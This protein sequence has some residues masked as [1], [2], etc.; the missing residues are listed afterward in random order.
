MKA[1]LGELQRTFAT[2][3]IVG[4]C[5]VLGVAMALSLGNT[6]Y[7][8]D[9]VAGTE[10]GGLK[11]EMGISPIQENPA[12]VIEYWTDDRMKTA[13]Q[14]SG[15]P[16][17]PPP[18]RPL[19]P[20]ADHSG[21]VPMTTPY[22]ANAI[23]R[24]NGVLFYEQPSKPVHCSASVIISRSQSLVLTAAH[25]VHDRPAGWSKCMLFVP[26]YNGAKGGERVPLG[27]WP[28]K[29]AFIPHLGAQHTYED[30]VAVL[31]IYP[32]TDPI[33][34]RQTVEQ[35]VGHA[36]QPLVTQD[37][38]LSGLRLFGYPGVWWASD[39]PYHGEQ[40]HCFSPAIPY[41]QT[42]ALTL[43][44]CS[45]QDG[46]SG[47]PLV[48]GAHAPW[49][50]VGVLHGEQAYSRLLPSTFTPIYEAADQAASR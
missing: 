7:A 8:G 36:F 1:I 40:R 43:E 21:Y 41:R 18:E 2:R 28:V 32:R 5:M 24:I 20:G 10:P 45:A 25:C 16:S 48:V 38:S 33:G 9:C 50:V 14:G 19:L 30:D 46:N 44:H 42:K 35:A 39:A 11:Q 34:R 6:V 3:V 13:E 15:M 47:G 37:G 27:K 26:A 23:S 4:M 22:T 29:Q 17:A 12:A 49:Y 31:S